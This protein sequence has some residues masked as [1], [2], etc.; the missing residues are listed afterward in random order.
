MLVRVL[1]MHVLISER[2]CN[3]KKGN[4][5]TVSNRYNL[6]FTYIDLISKYDLDI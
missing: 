6:I 2:L 1:I 4:T 3:A 5:Q